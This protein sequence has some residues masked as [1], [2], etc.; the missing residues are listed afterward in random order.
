MCKE[1]K[2][3]SSV[4]VKKLRVACMKREIESNVQARIINYSRILY[5]IILEYCLRFI[6]RPT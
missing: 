6:A 1:R 3:W 2:T 5:L 4:K